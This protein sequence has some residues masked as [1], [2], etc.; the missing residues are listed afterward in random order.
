[1]T[2]FLLM[3][4]VIIFRQKYELQIAH[5]YNLETLNFG[6]VFYLPTLFIVFSLTNAVFAKN[7]HSGI[8]FVHLI[9]LLAYAH[10]FYEKACRS[11]GINQILGQTT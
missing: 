3:A 8:I 2:K 5:K 4:V 1:M 7:N 10:F 9:F 6:K 11:L